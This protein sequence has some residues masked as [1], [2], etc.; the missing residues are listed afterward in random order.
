MSDGS[1]WGVERR[2]SARALLK[3]D[4][5]YSVEHP[6]E[7]KMNLRDRIETATLVDLGEGGLGFV[8]DTELPQDT[9]LEITFKIRSDERGDVEIRA[10]G[11]VKYCFP[12]YDYSSFRVGL[13]FTGIDQDTKGLIQ[14]YVK[15]FKAF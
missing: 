10:T 12:Q 11:V 1:F 2:R 3:T 15:N 5:F 13:E 7:L 9:R 8:S 14:E 4:L 6:P